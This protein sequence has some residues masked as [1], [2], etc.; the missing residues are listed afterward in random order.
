MR[1]VPDQSC[2]ENQNTHFKFNNFFL[3]ETRAF[4]Q[5]NAEKFGRAEQATDDN[6][7]HALCVLDT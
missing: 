3:I 7:A 4:C 5:I 6:T 1:N 2:T